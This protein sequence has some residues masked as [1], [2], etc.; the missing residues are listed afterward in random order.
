M[1][2]TYHVV[3]KEE[4]SDQWGEWFVG[5]MI[6]H[7]ENGESVLVATVVDQSELHG[8]L[9]RVGDLGLTLISVNPVQSNNR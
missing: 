5:L 3:I 6:T 7:N 8:L 2:E 4:L 1:T 9:M